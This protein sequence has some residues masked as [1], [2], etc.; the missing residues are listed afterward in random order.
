MTGDEL[1][2]RLKKL[3]HAIPTILAT[4]YPDEAVRGQALK[5]GVICY[6]SKRWTTKISSAAF[7]PL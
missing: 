6:L 7:V 4:A 1:H 3:G 5:D 2:R